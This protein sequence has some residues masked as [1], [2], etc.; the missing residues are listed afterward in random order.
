MPISR[1]VRMIRTAISPRLATRT[2]GSGIQGSRGGSGGGR[3]VR[4]RGRYAFADRAPP[5]VS[6]RMLTEHT[7]AEA[8]RVAGLTAPA[9]FAPVTGS[10]NTD[11]WQRAEQ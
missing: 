6:V 9:T 3:S 5:E 4:D 1:H 2:R 11:L 10:T 8:A 7:V